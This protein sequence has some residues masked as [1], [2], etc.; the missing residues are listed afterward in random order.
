[1]SS[2]IRIAEAAVICPIGLSPMQA[3]AA[4]RARIGRQ[5]RASLHGKHAEGFTMALLPEEVLGALDED[6]APAGSTDVGRRLL[7]LGRLALQNL[8]APAS[9][10][11]LF[12]ALPEM[13]DAPLGRTDGEWLDAFVKCSGVAI[14]TAASVMN[15]QGRAGGFFA[16]A[17]AFEYLSKGKGRVAIVGGIDTYM[18][19]LRLAALDKEERLL[20]EGRM[21]GFIP[22]EG[23]AFV[24]LT[25]AAASEGERAVFVRGV[26]TAL[27]RGHRYSAEP[28]LGVGLADA[29]EAL[30]S[31]ISVSMPAEVIFAGLN[32]EAEQAKEWGVAQ[33]RHRD[34]LSPE[35]TLEHPADCY[36]DLGAAT[37]PVLLALANVALTNGHREGPAFVWASSDREPCGCGWLAVQRQ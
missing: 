13:E 32:G 23:A 27:D 22:G 14:D 2:N 17:A 16:L 18:D 36:G 4:Y 30:R 9:P 31:T 24:F 19:P 12:L 26:G 37:G 35:A 21:N 3:W 11:P 34:I 5:K 8:K 25:N 6:A 10:A 1:M 29:I 20:V 28:D 33:I 7:K 15:R